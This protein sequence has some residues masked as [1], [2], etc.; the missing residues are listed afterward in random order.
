MRSRCK[1]KVRAWTITV[2]SSRFVY[3]RY[4]VYA[5]TYGSAC[6]KFFKSIRYTPE[7]TPEGRF[8]GV[9]CVPLISNFRGS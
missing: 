2:Y 7:S 4:V 9:S 6:R 5:R 8:E 3:S 1:Q